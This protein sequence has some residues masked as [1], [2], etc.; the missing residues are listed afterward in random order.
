MKKNLQSP[1]NF[2]LMQLSTVEQSESL[3]KYCSGYWK[4]KFFRGSLLDWVVWL[5]G[6]LIAAM[7]FFWT[8]YHFCYLSLRKI[9]SFHLI[10]WCGNFVEKKQFLH[11]AETMQK[12]FLS[13]KFSHQ[14]IKGN[15]SIFR[16]VS[17]FLLP[18]IIP[19][20]IPLCIFHIQ[21]VRFGNSI[22]SD[23]SSVCL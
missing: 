8:E 16:S 18:F 12:L 11:I 7:G 4:I 21:M 1:Y 22:F 5:T 19:Q 20:I 6:A 15:Y 14:Q 13:T 2:I 23:I 17:L 10:S 3:I 9:P